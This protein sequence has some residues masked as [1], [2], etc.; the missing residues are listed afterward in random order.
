MDI[1]GFFDEHRWLSNFYPAP[2]KI[3]EGCVAPT[4]EHLYQAVKVRDRDIRA[5]ILASK[6]PKD[7]KRIANSAEFVSGWHDKKVEV[8]RKILRLKFHGHP[9][10]YALLKSTSPC[11][12]EETNY[13]GDRFW[14]VCKGEGEN[15]LGKLLMSI[16]EECGPPGW[17]A[18]VLEQDDPLPNEFDV[19]VVRD[20]A[21]Y[22]GV[23]A[24]KRVG[25]QYVDYRTYL[26]PSRWDV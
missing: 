23:R 21:T 20:S 17:L 19:V 14:G 11:Y 22:V 8:M 1:R 16:R 4:S 5:K 7:A 24:L 18:G 13:W 25:D 12:L 9:E 15:W 26:H 6:S 2:I 10:L 3:N